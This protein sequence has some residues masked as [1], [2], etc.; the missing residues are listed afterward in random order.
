MWRSRSVEEFLNEALELW[1]EFTMAFVRIGAI[2]LTPIWIFPYLL[3]CKF[4]R[5]L[6]FSKLIKLLMNKD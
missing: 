1:I 3:Y 5:P 6:N 4:F 2:I